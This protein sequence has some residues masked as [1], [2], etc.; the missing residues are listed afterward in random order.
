MR[1]TEWSLSGRLRELKTKEKSSW[2]ILKV[3]EANYESGRLREL[4]ITKFKS[5]F[6]RGFTLVVV[7]RA[8]RLREWSQLQ[9]QL[10]LYNCAHKRFHMRVVQRRPNIRSH[11]V[12]FN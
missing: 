1:K 2:V 9:R 11:S 6:K 7:I 8:G 4:L 12:S 5:Q 3:V 10:R